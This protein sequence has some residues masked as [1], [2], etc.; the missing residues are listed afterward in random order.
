MIERYGLPIP[1]HQ[2]HG[3][4]PFNFTVPVGQFTFIE[5]LGKALKP[6]GAALLTEHASEY[7]RVVELP[8]H[9]EATMSL[10]YLAR[11]AAA[12]GLHVVESGSLAELISADANAQVVKDNWVN[13][14]LITGKSPDELVGETLQEPVKRQLG[15]ASASEAGQLPDYMEIKGSVESDVMKKILS[16]K[17]AYDLFLT[18]AEFEQYRAQ[19][20]AKDKRWRNERLSSPPTMAVGGDLDQFQYVILQKTG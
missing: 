7:P 20:S 6:S 14:V 2:A 17:R 4:S 5:E 15:W 18:P 10:K 9:K 16:E 12:N 1:P 19:R 3:D 13:C 11:V 8:G